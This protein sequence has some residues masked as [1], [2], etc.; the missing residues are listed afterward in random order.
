MEDP[1]QENTPLQ[2]LGLIAL[3]AIVGGV[4]WIQNPLTSSRPPAPEMPP[5][6]SYQSEY[7]QARLWEDPLQAVTRHRQQ[8]HTSTGDYSHDSQH[9]LKDFVKDVLQTHAPTV[10]ILMA[11]M[12][13]S[14]YVEGAESR[15]RTRYAILAGLNVSGYVPVN[16]GRLGYIDL[17]IQGRDDS[18]Q[19]IP[20]EWVAPDSLKP[21]A[22]SDPVVVLWLN[23]RHFQAEPLWKIGRLI[24]QIRSS[25]K[26]SEE[27]Q[28]TSPPRAPVEIN[29]ELIGPTDSN[30]L[31]AMAAD[32][33]NPTLKDNPTI[34][35][36]LHGLTIY[37]PW[38]TYADA[39]MVSPTH[40][41]TD[42][43]SPC[44]HADTSREKLIR[45][46][47]HLGITL[48]RTILTDAD[49]ARSLI[50][51]LYRRGFK[52][53]KMEDMPQDHIVV[54]A[55]WDTSYAR[56]LP[57]TLAAAFTHKKNHVSNEEVEK[58]LT[59]WMNQ[60]GNNKAIDWPSWIHRFSYLRGLD[61]EVSKQKDT[62]L[63]KPK[64]Y[65]QG[66]SENQPSL[67]S[68]NTRK[69]P[70]G[71]SQFDYLRRLVERIRF[72]KED[73]RAQCTFGSRLQDR[74]P[75]VKAIG[76]LGS[77]VYDKL[78][79]LQALR[80]QFPSTT[81]F[82]TDLDARLTHPEELSW[83]RNV[84]TISSFGLKLNPELQSDIPPF[85]SNYQTAIF[86]STLHAMKMNIPAKLGPFSEQDSPQ[87]RPRIFEIGNRG[88]N[89]LTPQD[90]HYPL[91]PPRDHQYT[92]WKHSIFTLF[93]AIGGMIVIIGILVRFSLNQTTRQA[94][95]SESTY[96]GM[97]LLLVGLMLASIICNIVGWNEW[98]ASGGKGEPL[99]MFD[100]ISI[101]PTEVIRL[102]AALCCLYFLGYCR[103][104]FLR[105]SQDLTK[106]FNLSVS[107]TTTSALKQFTESFTQTIAGLVRSKR[108]LFSEC[109]SVPELWTRYQH[110]TSTPSTLG[111][112]LFPVLLFFALG[113]ILTSLMGRPNVPFR[114]E[115]SL[116]MDKFILLKLS[117]PLLLFLVFWVGDLT[118]LSR[119][120]IL[121]L[122]KHSLSGPTPGL[123]GASNQAMTESNA[124]SAWILVRMIAYHTAVVG[125]FLL[126]PFAIVFLMIGSRITY[127]DNWDF[128]MALVV[129]F[130]FLLIYLL[131]CA[132]ALR[133]SAHSIRE[134]SI[135]QLK[136]QLFT[137]LDQ[138]PKHTEH[139]RFA[140]QEVQ[141][142]KEGAFSPVSQH[143]ILQALISLGGLSTFV[144]VEYLGLF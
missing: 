75:Q 74:C 143:P 57:L 50:A 130:A 9:H 41:E 87:D 60:L 15:L 13:G 38:A 20:Y 30:S 66:E 4:F 108:W 135:S 89:D 47:C 36:A 54:V 132:V 40:S 43:F 7:V 26:E 11:M 141:G 25:I 76:V 52:T 78:V 92:Q 32:T 94:H 97:R 127:W 112:C 114:G 109:S 137:R 122:S 46:F 53:S 86:Y 103:D 61:G 93:W 124:T 6:M 79:V 62:N 65:Q 88:A 58:K 134:E 83:T 2:G 17:G 72:I 28:T 116:S 100:G 101:W 49:L 91:H 117:V 140:L 44:S 10:R 77:D 48:D 90:E 80:K 133:R 18:T 3:A 69:R 111:R 71:L 31:I 123:P 37:S 23:D 85:R 139:L 68:L 29:I 98:I 19:V 118:M 99:T 102:L 67:F 105:N 14:P 125:R 129:I 144:I 24:Q 131:G 33:R 27:Q 138:D 142:L 84:L 136:E 107:N 51:E 73:L 120:F 39:L 113:F 95:Q 64:T 81:F 8:E 70:E 82:T 119:Q 16:A 128:P 110:L 96:Y 34:R 21:H 42:G 63:E 126:Y 1:K 56:V 12:D 59:I 22:L 115:F 106:Q 5:S 55:E 45:Q 35:A 121:H 104:A